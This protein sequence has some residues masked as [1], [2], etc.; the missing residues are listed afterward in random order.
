MILH[1]ILYIFANSGIVYYFIILTKM[2]YDKMAMT[3]R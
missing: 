3:S 2:L 1:S